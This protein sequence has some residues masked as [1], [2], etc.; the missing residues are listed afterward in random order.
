MSVLVRLFYWLF[1]TNH[2]TGTCLYAYT[3]RLSM[4]GN[5]LIDKQTFLIVLGRSECG[6]FYLCRKLH[7]LNDKKLLRINRLRRIFRV[8]S[9]AWAAIIVWNTHFSFLAWK[10]LTH[11]ELPALR[12]YQEFWQDCEAKLLKDSE[13][14]P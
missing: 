12:G 1:A 8:I 10:G 5:R 6:K 14:R 4:G 11:D 2:G 3:T 9:P 7:D 13:A